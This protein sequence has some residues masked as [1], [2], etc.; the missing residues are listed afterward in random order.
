MNVRTASEVGFCFG[1]KRAI[2]MTRQALAEE[3][4]VFILGDLIHNRSVTG[5][6]EARGLRKVDDL[7]DRKSGTMVVR[8][9]GLPEA[10]LQAAHDAGSG[11][12]TR[13][14]RSSSRPRR[15]RR[16]WSGAAARS[17]SSVIGTTRRSRGCWAACS[18]PRWWWTASRSCGRRSWTSGSAQ[19]GGDLPD[20]PLLR[21]VPGDRDG[22]DRHGQRGAG[23]Q[24]HL[25]PGAQPAAQ[26]RGSRSRGRGDGDRRQ[27]H[28]RQHPRAD[29]TSAPATTSGRSR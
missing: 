28:Q 8:A 16:S 27:P 26:R 18:A 24:H 1:V 23:D 22:A 12:W 29:S 11:S 13:P 6:L 14:A 17:S 2:N 7:S 3:D 10:Q 5:E 15:R 25:P 21:A 4:D 9:H 20:D 19:S